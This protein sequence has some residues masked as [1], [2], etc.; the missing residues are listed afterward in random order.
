MTLARLTAGLCLAT[1]A[2][3]GASPGAA[4]EYRWVLPSGFPAPTV[5]ADN[6]MSA[7]RVELGR[8]LFYDARLSGNGTQSCATCHQQD[9][10]FTDGRA[11]SIGS[12]GELHPRGSMSLVNVA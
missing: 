1:A 5:P 7:P 3:L 10:A 9:R 12:T 2:M 6:P 11:Q 4:E 8:Y